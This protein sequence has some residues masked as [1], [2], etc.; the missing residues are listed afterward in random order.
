LARISSRVRRNPG[1]VRSNYCSQSFA[2]GS[3]L[4][5]TTNT[6][7]NSMNSNSMNNNSEINNTENVAENAAE[8]AVSMVGAFTVL[9]RL[10]TAPARTCTSDVFVVTADALH[11]VSL[12]DAM[13]TELLWTSP[14]GDVV[15]TVFSPASNRMAICIGGDGD[16]VWD[17]IVHDMNTGTAL[18][19]PKHGPS[20][21]GL[22]IC[23]NNMGTRL[24]VGGA[25]IHRMWDIDSGTEVFMINNIGSDTCFSGDDT[26]IISAHTGYDE[27]SINIWNAESAAQGFTFP[28][29]DTQLGKVVSSLRGQ[30]GAAATYHQFFVWDLTTG[31]ALLH[32]YESAIHGLLFVRDDTWIIGFNILKHCCKCWDIATGSVVYDIRFDYVGRAS[33]FGYLPHKAT[34]CVVGNRDSQVA[35]YD[36]ETGREVGRSTVYGGTIYGCYTYRPQAILL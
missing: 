7:N 33:N 15:K 35:E 14:Y 12:W 30:M 21:Q 3:D 20:W 13:N 2:N 22:S 29:V 24:L 1:N 8:R 34:F 4:T 17:T 9:E 25:S 10:R 31:Q 11:Y 27:T 16:T 19:L 23:M 28:A 26:R 5:A 36:V 32:K 6:V 18:Q